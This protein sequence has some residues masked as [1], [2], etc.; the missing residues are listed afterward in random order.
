MRLHTPSDV[1]NPLSPLA[2]LSLGA[3]HKVLVVGCAYGG[4]SAVVNLL[5]LIQGKGLRP[6]GYEAADFLGRKSKNGV[7]I[8]V[9][10]ERDGYCTSSPVRK[11]LNRLSIL[12]QASV[13]CLIPSL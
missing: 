4:I 5:D 1:L 7:E 3:P 10:D 6:S 13:Y 2:S 12:T 8:T 9:I 11:Q